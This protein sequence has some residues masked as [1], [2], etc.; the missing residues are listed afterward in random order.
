[1]KTVRWERVV[2]L[3]ILLGATTIGT[4]V[5]TEGVGGDCDVYCK[6]CTD[7]TEKL[8]E[9]QG[10]RVCLSQNIEIDEPWYS[11]KR[12]SDEISCI[13]LTRHSEN[14][15]FDCKGHQIKRREGRMTTAL[16][17]R[18]TTNITIENCII[19]G[20]ENGIRVEGGRKNI[21]R[22]NSIINTRIGIQTGVLFEI[23]FESSDENLIEMNRII[24]KK[25]KKE[26]TGVKIGGKGNIVKENV[27][28][29]YST[30]VLLLPSSHETILKKNNVSFNYYGIEEAASGIFIENRVCKNIIKDIKATEGVFINNVCDD[31]VRDPTQ[32]SPCGTTKDDGK[33]IDEWIVVIVIMVVVVV[34]VIYIMK[35][36]K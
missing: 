30:G 24:N 18:R 12:K 10:G 36:K 34:I 2:L 11:F 17:M 15:I 1:M 31:S 26:S 32:C 20:F 27:I 33:K 6:N 8:Y 22:N 4:A 9:K 21:I 28:E 29:N 19:R 14:V 3:I 35:N 23:N 5:G 16:S 13:Y 7:C 25:L